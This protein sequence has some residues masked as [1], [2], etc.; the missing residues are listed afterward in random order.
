MIVR[1]FDRQKDSPEVLSKLNDFNET[2]Q[3][4]LAERYAFPFPEKNLVVAE[5]SGELVGCLHILD[6]GFPFAILDGFYIKPEYRSLENA[7]ALGHFAED[8]LRARGVAAYIVY[9]PERLS[10]GLK[11]CGLT[12]SPTPFYMLARRLEG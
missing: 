6:G 5:E 10:I 1:Y 2:A 12:Y 7:L 4:W 9:A 11:H 3:T 8:E